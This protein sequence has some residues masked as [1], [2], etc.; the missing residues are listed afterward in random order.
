MCRKLVVVNELVLGNRVLGYE[1]LS[2]PKG[3]DRG[4]YTEAVKGYDN[5]ERGET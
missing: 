3:G 5:H 4:I 2:F 1:T